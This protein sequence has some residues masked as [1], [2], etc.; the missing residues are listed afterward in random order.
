MERHALA[1]AV[2]SAIFGGDAAATESLSQLA[3]ALVVFRET[4]SLEHGG[5]DGEVVPVE[6]AVAESLAVLMLTLASRSA[7]RRRS[8]DMEAK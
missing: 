3:D 7:L 1:R 5:R 8:R 4:Q 2:R 6:Y